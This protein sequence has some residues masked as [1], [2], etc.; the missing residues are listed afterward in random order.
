V[1][2]ISLEVFDLPDAWFQSLY[3]CYTEGE[4]FIVDHGS[5]TG[6]TKTICLSLKVLHPNLK[7]LLHEKAPCDMNY[8]TKQYLPY[9]ITPTKQP[10]EDYTYGERMYM[11]IIDETEGSRLISFIDWVI[12]GLKKYPYCRHYAIPIKRPEDYSLKHPPCLCLVDFQIDNDEFNMKQLH[13]IL[14]FRSWDIYAGMPANLAALAMLQEYIASQ[15]NV[16]VGHLI[17]FSK[18]AHIYKRC[19]NFVEQVLYPKHE[20]KRIL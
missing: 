1:K 4:I 20:R 7:P 11:K 15:L 3:K 8:I 13:M 18:N 14:Y 9:L 16:K 10:G 12:E 6:E 2:Y 5:E 17:A 19:Y